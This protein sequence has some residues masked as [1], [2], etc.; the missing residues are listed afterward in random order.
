MLIL[1]IK[2]R[3]KLNKVNTVFSIKDLE[4]LSGI[5]AHTIRIWEKR[6]QI[7][8]PDRTESNIRLYSIDNLQKLL[9]VTF[10]YNSGLK[11]SKIANL[12]ISEIQNMVNDL[13]SK[14]RGIDHFLDELKI[15]MFSYDQFKFE[16]I[17]NRLVSEMSF[18]KVFLEVFLPLLE[19]IG[20]KWQTNSITHAHERFVSNLIHQKLLLNMEQVKQI[21]PSP[22][23]VYVLFLPDEEIH[24][25]GLLYIAYELEVEGK[26]VVYLGTGVSFDSLLSVLDCYPRAKFVSYFTVYPSEKEVNTYLKEI[27]YRVL[28]K[29]DSDLY[30]FGRVAR[31]ANYSKPRITLFNNTI[32]GLNKVC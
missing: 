20:F 22:S 23:D 18:R 15:A 28:S 3:K 17:Y 4:N 10:L 27:D 9:N 1:F 5:K 32:E 7:L 13:S 30:V 29:N 16:L 11:I 21:K 14:N 8:S 2:F 6:Y 26:Q 19:Y 25:L 31:N 12:S 24:E